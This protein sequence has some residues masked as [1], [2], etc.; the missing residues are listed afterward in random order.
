MEGGLRKNSG[1]KPQDRSHLVLK[2]CCSNECNG[3]TTRCYWSKS[4][5]CSFDLF[6]G[7][8]SFGFVAS[9]E[10][11]DAFMRQSVSPDAA[12]VRHAAFKKSLREPLEKRLDRKDLREVR[13]IF[14]SSCFHF[15][16][17]SFLAAFS[18]SRS[19]FC[20]KAVSLDGR[21]LVRGLST[22]AT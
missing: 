9:F 17:F 21:P 20:G 7:A 2:V 5:V 1:K 11:A 3:S 8:Q 15:F 4:V 14:P 16:S 10:I 12:S 13:S 18:F 22:N 6:A 19:L